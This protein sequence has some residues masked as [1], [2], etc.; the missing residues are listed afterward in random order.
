MRSPKPITVVIACPHC[1]TRYQV[2][3][4]TLGKTGR[5]VACAH[6]GQ[7]WMADPGSA[8]PVPEPDDRLFNEADEKALDKSFADE[9][10]ALRDVPASVRQLLPKGAVPPPEVM[11]SISEIKAALE[12]K[13]GKTL[14]TVAPPDSA[15]PSPAKKQ[16]QGKLRQRQQAIVDALPVAQLGRV[17][18]IAGIGLL[19]AV[20]GGGILFRTEIVRTLPDLAGLYSSVGLTVNVIG[21]EFSEVTTVVSR[22]GASDVMT[23]HAT[24]AGAERRR[25]VVPP[26]VVTLLGDDGSPVYAW[27]VAPKQGDLE[28]GEAIVFSAEL[29][30][31]PSGAR[32]VRL[33]FADSTR[34]L[35]P[36]VAADAQPVSGPPAAETN[37]DHQAPAEHEGNSH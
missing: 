10:A 3:P 19:L 20:V 34:A 36:I 33:S 22:R 24:I 16:A 32:Q 9:E 21:L 6:C 25:V 12:S 7:S 4:E 26:V 18:R 11:R 13:T 8:L 37:T 15:P 28:P 27:S 29:A 1:G 31:P 2:P 35:A 14:S 23:V 17:L 30:S 5:K